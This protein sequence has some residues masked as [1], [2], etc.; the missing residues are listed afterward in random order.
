MRINFGSLLFVH[1]VDV[2]D[3]RHGHE[4]TVTRGVY[5]V[6]AAEPA[7]GCWHAQRRAYKGTPS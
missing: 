1:R 3:E 7:V 4:D 6:Q 5:T 2:I